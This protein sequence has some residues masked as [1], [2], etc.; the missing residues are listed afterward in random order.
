MI[1]KNKITDKYKNEYSPPEIYADGES[2]IIKAADLWNL[3]VI[4]LEMIYEI[5]PFFL[6]MFQK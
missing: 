1:K 2:N 3:G 5:P 6:K 4:V